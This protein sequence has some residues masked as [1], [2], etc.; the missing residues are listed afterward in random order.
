MTVAEGGAAARES[1]LH[2]LRETIARFVALDTVTGSRALYR[3]AVG[4]FRRGVRRLS[5]RGAGTVPADLAA[6][7][8]ELGEV[9]AWLCYDSEQQALSWRVSGQALPL[10]RAAGDSAMTRFLLSHRSMQAAY[11]GRGRTALDLAD[12][13]LAERPRSRR[14]TAMMR[15][16]RARA[17]GVLGDGGGA[18][19][20][21]DR[22]R[23]G[24]DGGVTA[25][26]PVWTW[27]LHDAELAAHE[28]EIRSVVGDVRG[29][30]RAS[31]AAVA[32]LPAGQG[33]DQVLY[34]AARIDDLINA[35]AWSEAVEV[36]EEIIASPAAVGTER[37]PRMLRVSAGQ[38]GRSRAPGLLLD[39]LRHAAQIAGPPRPAPK[40]EE[41]T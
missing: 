9:A 19:A 37:V 15:V 33:R 39:A 16:R 26:D 6:A 34:R 29:A 35:G 17:L 30:V 40:T 2:R 14:V 22:A 24:L 11:L 21:L 1:E 10:A 5:R 23:A 3:T 4:E 32:L 8:A 12:R 36:T 27:W 7:L 38:A 25:D 18:L 41:E 13:A 31:S 20:E 28:A